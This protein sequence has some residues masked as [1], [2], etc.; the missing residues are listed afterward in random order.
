M[1]NR[2]LPQWSAI[3]CRQRGR[4]SGYDH[5]ASEWDLRHDMERYDFCLLFRP[6]WTH[7]CH[8]W[9]PGS[10]PSVCT[11]SLNTYLWLLSLLKH[12]RAAVIQSGL[13]VIL[14]Q[15]QWKWGFPLQGGTSQGLVRGRA[16]SANV[17]GTMME[18][19]TLCA[20][21]AGWSDPAPKS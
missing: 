5:C 16:D 11:M 13:K 18:T 8:P 15:R 12:Q 20:R 14:V 17:A 7:T 9:A 2:K 6:V 4:S 21:K 10:H 19:S 1:R 3:Q